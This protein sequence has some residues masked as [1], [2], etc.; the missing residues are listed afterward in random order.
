MLFT[1]A[2][3][4]QVSRNGV[5][6]LMEVKSVILAGIH[7]VGVQRLVA[8][9]FLPVIRREF[10]NA[11]EVHCLADFDTVAFRKRK[12]AFIV[13]RDAHDGAFAVRHQHVVADPDR[14]ISTRDRVTD[15][16]VR[17]D[18]LLFLRR[19][20]G[21]GNAALRALSNES[22]NRGIA[23]RGVFCERVLGR[24]GDERHAHDRVSARRV[25][26]ELMLFAFKRIGEGKVHA[27]AAADPMALHR[28]DLIRPAVEL[29]DVVQQ[30]LSV[31]RD[32]EVVARNLLTLNHGAGTPAAAI[33]HL[34]VGEHGL[35]HRVPVHHLSLAV[36]DAALQHL[37]EDPLIPAVVLRLAGRHFARPVKGEP[38]RRHLRLHVSDVRVRPL[39]GR[40]LLGKRGVFSRQAEGIPSHRSHDVVAAHTA[41]TV[42]HVIQGVVAYVAHVK[43]PGRIGKH[44]ANIVFRFFMAGGIKR[45]L[46]RAVDILCLPLG[47]NFRFDEFR[48]VGLTHWRIPSLKEIKS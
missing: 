26:A 47:L 3:R 22:G 27:F 37:Q 5:D 43:L 45:M 6:R 38:Q 28:A 15:R 16:E 4:L 2:L 18:A 23:L 8:I 42:Q 12:V 1:K 29:I 25:N 40:H 21:F 14:N 39:R 20:I 19:H 33:N 35:V 7:A 24:H 46:D 32:T 44:R 11:V 34:L 13:R 36:G 30:L 41:V 10:G 48:R 9:P 31:L 17:L